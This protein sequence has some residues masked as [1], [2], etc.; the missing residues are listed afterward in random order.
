MI[1][2]NEFLQ[3]LFLD[4]RTWDLAHLAKNVAN[5]YTKIFII[6]GLGVIGAFLLYPSKSI[7]L[8]SLYS[9]ISAVWGAFILGGSGVNWNSI[10]DLIISLTLIV[11]ILLNQLSGFAQKNI[12]YATGYMPLSLLFYYYHWL[13]MP[14][15]DIEK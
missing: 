3:G 6:I 8:L 7:I 1:Y 15:L 10:F 9:I 14:P 13:Y 12:E 4:S 2:G 5:K 11:G